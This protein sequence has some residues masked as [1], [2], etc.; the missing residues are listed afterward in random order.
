M[1]S[2]SNDT[3]RFWFQNCNELVHKND[4]C[5]FEYDVA[6][7]A[8]KGINFMSF[9]ETCINS[10][11]P[12]FTRKLRDSFSNIIPN[13]N[14]KFANSPKYPKRICYQL[15]GVASGFDGLLR[16]RYLREGSDHIGKWVWQEFGHGNMITRVYTLYE[17][18]HGSEMTSGASTAWSQQKKYWKKVGI[19]MT[20]VTRS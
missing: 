9:S 6:M 13:G 16:I 8:D 20:L 4:I 15:G 7:L 17:V 19:S 18:N 5:E 1:Q 14:I 10:N 11:K 12:G 3:V 2:A